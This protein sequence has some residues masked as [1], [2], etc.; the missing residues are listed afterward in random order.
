MNSEETWQCISVR[1]WR[2]AALF[3][4]LAIALT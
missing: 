4:G 1:P 2:L 3:V